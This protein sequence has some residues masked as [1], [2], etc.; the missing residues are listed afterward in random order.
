M[1]RFFVAVLLLAVAVVALRPSEAPA[2]SD[3]EHG[4]VTEW[5]VASGGNGHYYQVVCSNDD[6]STADEANDGA[7]AL[8]GHLATLTSSDE[9][10]FVF[11]LLGSRGYWYGSED[12]WCA[13]P[14]IGLYEAGDDN[15]P[16]GDWLWVTG[17]EFD[18]EN[19]AGSEP[20]NFDGNDE[21]RA[22]YG[23]GDCEPVFSA[24][25]EWYD[26][27]EDD[28]AR[29]FVV[30][31]DDA[32]PVCTNTEVMEWPVADG[33]NGH[34][35]Q[36][37]CNDDGRITWDEARDAAEAL[38]GHLATNASE[39]ENDFVFDLID[40]DGFWNLTSYK[41]ILGPWI[42]GSQPPGSGEPDEGWEWVTS[43]PFDYNNWTEDEPDN[44]DDDDAIVYWGGCPE[45][46]RTDEWADLVSGGA[47]EVVSYVVEWE[48]APAILGDADCD[49]DVDF[50][51]VQIILL[52][53]ATLPGGESCSAA[54][55]VGTQGVDTRDT[56]CD[57]DVDGFDA[58]LV[59]RYL[60]ELPALPLL[61][62][63]PA[64]GEP[65]A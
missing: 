31:W 11:E 51:D 29:S 12:G 6:S 16:D 44:F 40:R 42:G 62:E 34:F 39:E 60:V 47:G 46:G 7:L 59:L 5:T 45:P 52:A 19:W 65:I 33:G 15:E 2:G 54:T 20:N 35:Y 24:T 37:R 55:D 13:G 53:A 10:D 1:R 14:I 26:I 64:V 9:N 57:P 18:Y 22:S 38:G 48:V 4:Q 8:G 58:L 17:E 43:E 25:D 3:C 49:G 50:D 61:T 36:G 28:D 41:C 21:E 63:C 30:E 32:P 27:G 56:D 23:N